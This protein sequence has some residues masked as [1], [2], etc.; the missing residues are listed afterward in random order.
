MLAVA[1]EQAPSFPN[2]AC[3]S[4]ALCNKRTVAAG[5]RIQAAAVAVSDLQDEAV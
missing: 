3:V 2:S 1:V 4:V 5:F